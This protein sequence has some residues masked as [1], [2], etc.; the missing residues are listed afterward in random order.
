MQSMSYNKYNVYIN[1]KAP[2]GNLL[3]PNNT[4]MSKLPVKRGIGIWGVTETRLKTATCYF[5]K[6]GKK[7]W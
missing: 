4:F 1:S 3:N 6:V 5:Q 2:V 7:T